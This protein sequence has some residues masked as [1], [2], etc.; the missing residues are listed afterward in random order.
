MTLKYFNYYLII[1]EFYKEKKAF[2]FEK[3]CIYSTCWNLKK[4]M[5]LLRKQVKE[6]YSGKNYNKIDEKF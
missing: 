5:R 3:K 6:N 2:T 4:K 1:V